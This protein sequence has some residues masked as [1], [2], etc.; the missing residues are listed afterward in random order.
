MDATRWKALA[1]KPI[2]ARPLEW[3]DQ[4][5]VKVTR[6]RRIAVPRDR[7]WEAVADHARWP[8]WFD[9]LTLVEPLE[10]PEGVGGRRRVHI[11]SI[12]VEEE[13]LA[14]EPG[15]RFAFTVTHST[16]PG[17]RSMVEDVRL[18][19][20]GDSATTVS[21]TQAIEPVGGRLTGPLVRRVAARNLDSGLA[22]LAAHVGG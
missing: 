17:I 11:R 3:I 16:K 5:P 12:A 1:M 7:V 14:W 2:T 13:F 15:A 19:P 20:D 18:V 9:A 8:E 22:G 4:A 10:P 21:Y 6:T